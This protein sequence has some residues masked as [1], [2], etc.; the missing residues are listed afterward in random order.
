MY[1][2][3]LTLP[4]IFLCLMWTGLAV[5]ATESEQYLFGMDENCLTKITPVILMIVGHHA[6]AAVYPSI[7]KSDR[8]RLGSRCVLKDHCLYLT[9][10]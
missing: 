5:S 6:Q 3:S 4:C 7:M 1:I 10:F 2:S 8:K 9:F